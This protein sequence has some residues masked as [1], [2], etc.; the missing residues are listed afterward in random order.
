MTFKDTQLQPFSYYSYEVEVQNQYGL[1]RSTAVTFQTLAGTPSSDAVLNVSGVCVFHSRLLVQ[2]ICTFCAN[3]PLAATG[4][5]VPHS[6]NICC[7]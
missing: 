5:L 1:V 3:G 4:V 6:R 2:R 7:S